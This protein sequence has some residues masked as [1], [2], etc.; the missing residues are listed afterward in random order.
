MDVDVVVRRAFVYAL[1][2]VAI[3][4]MIGVIAL[5]LV[6]LALG[7]NLSNTEIVLR[8]LIAVVAMAAIVL[9]SE[10]LK[11][12][13][14]E[15]TERYFYGEKYDLRRGLL[16]FGKTLSAT[17]ALNP[18][19]DALTGRLEQV[20]DVEKIAVFIEDDNARAGYRVAKSKGLSKTYEIPDDFRTMIRQESAKKGVVRADQFAER[21]IEVTNGNGNVNGHA[22]IRQE[23]HYFVPCVARG[24]MVAVIGLGRAKNGSLLSSE[25]ISIL[26]TASGYIA[27]S[28][29][30]SLLYQEQQDRAEEL[31]LLKEFNESIVESVNVGL[32]AVDEN[33]L[34]TRCNSTFEEILGYSRD[35]SLGKPIKEIFDEGFARKIEN[36]LGEDRWHLTEIR[37]AYKLESKDRD[38]RALTLNVAIAPLRSMSEDQKGAIVVLENVTQRV[39]FEENLQQSE[40]LSSIGLLA[41]GVAH[42]VNTPLTGVSSYTQMLMGM[43]P[44]TDPKHALL[45]KVQKQ[46][47]R[48]TNIVGNLLN[49]SRTGNATEFTELDINKLLEDTLQLLEP[50]LRKSNV[51]I[52]KDYADIPPKVYGNPGKLQQVFTNL[53]INARDAILNGGEIT[54]RTAYEDDG[55]ISIEVSDTGTGIE[56]EHL[57]KIFDPFFTT[58]AVGS[59]TGLG[60]AVTYGIVQEHSGTISASSKVGEGTTF[61]LVLPIAEKTQ[62]QRVAS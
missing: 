62:N 59:G 41:A 4:A 28:L 15:R 39:K 21:E 18:L 40:K 17:T 6:F 56:P 31:A 51:E 58:K 36:I 53:I 48:A 49:F 19:L 61:R 24:K 5:G 37:N 14:Q 13:L 9:L 12:F 1:T 3:A 7:E 33:G 20:L 23:L 25:D 52:L 30:N 43:I 60:M 54:L 47:E 55:E 34:I 35:E 8:G 50:Q 27:V 16:D 32:I 38:G 11:N 2:T 44:E 42:E 26:Q 22:I 57:S 45:E 10:P 46:T 29:E